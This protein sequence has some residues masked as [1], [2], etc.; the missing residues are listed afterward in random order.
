MARIPF[1]KLSL[2]GKL[3][4]HQLDRPLLQCRREQTGE[5]FQRVG[6]P[7]GFDFERPLTRLGGNV[8]QLADDPRAG[9]GPEWSIRSTQSRAVADSAFL[10]SR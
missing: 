5:L 2:L 9:G 10:S 1:K 6:K 8:E 4:N 3:C 7:E